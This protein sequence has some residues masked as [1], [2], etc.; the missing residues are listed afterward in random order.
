MFHFARGQ[1]KTG[2][3]EQSTVCAN[4]GRKS[5]WEVREENEGRGERKEKGVLSCT[6]KYLGLN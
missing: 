2:T 3:L 4:T 5:I 1:Y 6:N